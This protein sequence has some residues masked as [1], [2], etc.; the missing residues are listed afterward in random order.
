MKKSA[1][2]L[3][4]VISATLPVAAFAIDNS[5]TLSA[6]LERGFDKGASDI[7]IITAA[8]DYDP[9]QHMLSVA[10]PPTVQAGG[11]NL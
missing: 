1:L 4:F 7:A 10:T 6:S 5:G 11:T 2:S 8:R 9:L 3:L